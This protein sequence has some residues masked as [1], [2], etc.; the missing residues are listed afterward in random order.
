MKDGSFRAS[1]AGGEAAKEI[2]RYVG[3]HGL[4]NVNIGNANVANF[5]GAKPEWGW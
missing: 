2:T 4:E 1:K 3:N 5:G